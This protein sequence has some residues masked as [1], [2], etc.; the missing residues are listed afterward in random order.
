MNAVTGVALAVGV[1][2]ALMIFAAG[3]RKRV[4]LDPET[5]RK[6]VHVGSGILAM[7]FPWL[8]T[9]PYPVAA[10]CGV[11]AV[12]LL[13]IRHT[14]VF[15]RMFKE[16]LGSVDRGS[17]GEFYFPLAV[18]L[19]FPLSRGDLALYLIPVCVLTFSDTA[20]AVL[21]SRYGLTHYRSM[22]GRKS[23]EGSVAF[24]VVTLAIT[25]CLLLQWS[26]RDNSELLLMALSVAVATTLVEA[27]ATGGTDNLAVPLIAFL[28]LFLSF[29]QYSLAPWIEGSVVAVLGFILVALQR[30]EPGPGGP[31]YLRR[32]WMYLSEMFPVPLRVVTAGIYFLGV[33]SMVRL[34]LDLETTLWTGYTLLGVWTFFCHMLIL[35]LM[36]ELKD[37]DVDR[38]LFPHRPVPSGRVGVG[39]I[40]SGLVL[41][42]VAFVVPNISV[43]AALWMALVLLAYCFLMFRF[44]F[45]PDLLRE[46]LLLNLAT[47]N[48][49]VAV[50]LLYVMAVVGAEHGLTRADADWQQVLLLIAFFWPPTFAWEIARKIRS[51]EEEDAYVT[52]SRIFGR[53]GA[54]LVVAGAQSVSLLVGVHFYLSLQ[55]SWLFL[56]VLVGAFA[57]AQWGHLRFALHPS[58][59]TSQLRPYAEGFLFGVLA[60]SLLEYLLGSNFNQI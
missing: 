39:D 30:R 44:F 15:P 46:N 41:A 37:I 22:S 24:F 29:G 21:G 42:T 16:A 31:G 51:Q 7:S 20:A 49:V 1:V 12:G 59:T 40:K 47:H 25:Y 50:G 57:G 60:A 2:S 5:A 34:T 3:L 14:T 4:D 54:L 23:I 43:Q 28:F 8:F 56:L 13:V 55:L 26:G 10:A 9:S 33:A 6:I 36:D 27:V 38:E 45:I 18:A 32:M 35:R 17:G 53:R 58:P 48:P 19:L 52:Y 11:S